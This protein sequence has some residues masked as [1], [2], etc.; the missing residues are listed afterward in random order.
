MSDRSAWIIVLLLITVTG[1]QG[2]TEITGPPRTETP[3]AERVA[4][5]GIANDGTVDPSQ[6]VD[7]HETSLTNRSYTLRE[8]LVVTYANGSKRGVR[9]T[10]QRIGP[11]KERFLYEMNQT[12]EFPWSVPPYPDMEAW[13]DGNRTYVRL[14]QY[15]E[16]EYSVTKADRAPIRSNIFDTPF[17]IR[18]YLS[19]VNRTTVKPT[20]K[21][22]WQSYEVSWNATNSSAGFSIRMLVNSFGLIYRFEVAY[23]VNSAQWDGKMS[24]EFWIT[25][26][27]E[28]TFNRPDWIAAARNAS[29]T[30][31]DGDR[32]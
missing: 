24:R 17:I 9:T 32:Q 1:C 11:Q 26:I 14:I 8:R 19:A 2:I 18:R 3:T 16:V 22:G 4:A 30:G 5:P 27:G 29:S 23:A 31:T 21:D 25:D 6:V 12:G 7:A 13:S 15:D 28:T 20:T 10:V